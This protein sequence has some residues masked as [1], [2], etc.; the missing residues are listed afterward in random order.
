M[1][2]ELIKIINELKEALK[3]TKLLVMPNDLLDSAIK[4]YLTDKIGEQKFYTKTNYSKELK[5][6]FKT[7]PLTS[8]EEP[9][10]ESQIKAM[11]R[12]GLT[13]PAGAS[14]KELWKII[15]EFKEKQK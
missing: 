11:K 13:I 12:F 15:K 3:E 14:K 4:I 8:K 1:K 2:T 10:T 6:E 7:N 5:N 9:P